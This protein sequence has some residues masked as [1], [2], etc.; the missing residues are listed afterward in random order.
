MTRETLPQWTVYKVSSLVA[1]A[2]GQSLRKLGTIEAPNF[3]AAIE[4][5]Q[6]RF[7]M[8]CD[9]N[10]PTGGLTVIGTHI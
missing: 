6:L 5:A 1:G 10:A 8:E 2:A 3:N 7:P 4:A 9:A